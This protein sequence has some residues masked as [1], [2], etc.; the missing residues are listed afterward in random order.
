MHIYGLKFKYTSSRLFIFISFSFYIPVLAN[1]KHIDIPVVIASK[2][3]FTS[4][5]KRH[6]EEP[7]CLALVG[8]C[9]AN[10]RHNDP[11]REET[12]MHFTG[13]K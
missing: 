9:T 7:N 3:R 11:E 10:Y 1:I 6:M 4:G 12:H 2:E 5:V 13:R 8:R